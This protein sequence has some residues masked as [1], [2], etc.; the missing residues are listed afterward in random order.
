MRL[1]VDA[2]W[3]GS[4]L[5]PIA[6]ACYRPELDQSLELDERTSLGRVVHLGR[7]EELAGL[8]WSDLGGHMHRAAQS[9]HGLGSA[10]RHDR[11]VVHGHHVHRVEIAVDSRAQNRSDQKHVGWCWWS[12]KVPE[13]HA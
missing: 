11:E 9:Y 10:A 12:L 6:F 2:S 3:P 5:V 7:D 4:S 13:G 1:S 8:G